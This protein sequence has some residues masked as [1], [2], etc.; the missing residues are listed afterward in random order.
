[1]QQNP[2]HIW[3]IKGADGFNFRDFHLG[4]S[5]NFSQFLT[6]GCMQEDLLT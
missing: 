5:P 6:P 1:M 2:K 4:L 3:M